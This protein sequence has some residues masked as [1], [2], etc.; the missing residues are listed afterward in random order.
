MKIKIGSVVQIKSGG[1]N[2]T[3][4]GFLDKEH[5]EQYKKGV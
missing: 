5:R 3:V 2:M 1:P 4:T